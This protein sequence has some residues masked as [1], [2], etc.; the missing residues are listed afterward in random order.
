MMKKRILIEGNLHEVG[1]RPFLL[2]LA[3]AL[4]IER[5]FADNIHI[6][7]G[8]QAVEVLID[9]DD[10]KVEALLNAIKERRPENARVDEV[11]VEDYRGHVMRTESYY[12]YLTAMQLAKI[13]TYGG[14]MLDKQDMTLEKQDRMLEKQD[15]ML[16][17]QDETLK[18][19]RGVKEEVA[20]I[21]SKLDKTN[22]LLE[23]RFERLEQE[24]ERVK[25]ALI[26]AGIDIP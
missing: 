3:E 22:E 24:I 18:E 25:R 23:S 15:R 6:I 9:A 13:A 17:K 2:G 16:E 12:R 20:S 4:E 26:K 5:L 1:Y 8:K 7:N 14:R 19:I 10:D 21:S 11:R